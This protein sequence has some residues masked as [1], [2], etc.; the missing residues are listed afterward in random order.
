MTNLQNG[1]TEVLDPITIVRWPFEV[2]EEGFFLEP[3]ET[4]F[5]HWHSERSDGLKGLVGHLIPKRT[6]PLPLD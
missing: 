2:E 6:R 1:G 3:P 5:V 4:V